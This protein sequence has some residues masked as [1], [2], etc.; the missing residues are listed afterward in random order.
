[1]EGSLPEPFM[2][3]PSSSYESSSDG[4]SKS[5]KG[6]LQQ[7]DAVWNCKL[8][9]TLLHFCIVDDVAFDDDDAYI[10]PLYSTTSPTRTASPSTLMPSGFGNTSTNNTNTSNNYVINP[11]LQL[12]DVESSPRSDS[13]SGSSNNNQQRQQSIVTAFAPPPPPL[14]IQQVYKVNAPSPPTSSSRRNPPS[15]T[16][17]RAGV[18]GLFDEDEEGEF[19]NSGNKKKRE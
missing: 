3:A 6:M 8:D 2:V 4:R 11:T 13:S 12:F 14:K 18:M 16:A 10:V 19:I 15:V 5:F 9:L 1:M 7:A 17:D